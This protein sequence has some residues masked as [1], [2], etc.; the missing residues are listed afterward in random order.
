MW[1]ESIYIG[2]CIPKVECTQ[3]VSVSRSRL[4]L[5]A[6]HDLL[7]ESHSYG[8]ALS[9]QTKFNVTSRRFV[10]YTYVYS[11]TRTCTLYNR[12]TRTCNVVHVH[13][14][15]EFMFIKNSTFSTF[16]STFVRKY[17]RKYL[18][19]YFRTKSKATAVQFCTTITRTRLEYESTFV[20]SKVRKYFRTDYSKCTCTAVTEV[21]KYFRTF[22]R[23][24]ES[25][26]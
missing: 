6:R 11:C 10:T 22:V 24:Y 4:L 13:Y 8:G 19:K 25:T 3:H 18:R 5:K 1:C 26:K 14:K 16:D 15:L 2:T 9:R 20:L 12:C 7:K 17:V 21:R 23:K